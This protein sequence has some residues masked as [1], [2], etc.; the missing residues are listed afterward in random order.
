MQS[1]PHFFHVDERG[2]SVVRKLIE[3]A[4]LDVCRAFLNE[5]PAAAQFV[6]PDLDNSTLLHRVVYRTADHVAVAQEI[7]RHFQEAPYVTSDNAST[8]YRVAFES[9]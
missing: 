4:P 9:M 2:R 5:F 7:L 8:Q 3:T 6:E 1:N